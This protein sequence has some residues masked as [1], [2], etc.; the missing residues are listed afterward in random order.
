MA[1]EKIK[2][3]TGVFASAFAH[4]GHITKEEAKEIAGLE[5]HEFEKVYDKAA[6]ISEKMMQAGG[7][8]M[9]K[10]LEHFAEEIEEYM[11]HFGGK[12]FD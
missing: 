8:K 7:K 12:L 3:M 5:D 4:A 9:D 11:A 6:A 1:K 2:K 10:F